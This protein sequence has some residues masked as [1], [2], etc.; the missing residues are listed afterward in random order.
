[1]DKT[2]IAV[3][4]TRLYQISYFSNVSIAAFLHYTLS[5]IF[6]PDG[7]GV[8]ED[9]EHGVPQSSDE[10]QKDTDLKPE[11][12]VRMEYTEALTAYP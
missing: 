12:E 8:S 2:P 5:I 3:G 4:W 1:M 7:Q 11:G 6:P 9:W 10:R